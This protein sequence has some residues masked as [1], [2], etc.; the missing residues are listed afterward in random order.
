MTNVWSIAL[1]AS[2]P[3]QRRKN[4]TVEKLGLLKIGYIAFVVC[5]ATALA[6]P[7]QTFTSLVSF[8][9]IDGANPYAGL[10]Q[11]TDG[12]LY[13][14]TFQGP[15]NG[16]NQG[17]VFKMTTTGTLTPLYTFCSQANCA[18]GA[19][20]S[21]G[22]VLGTDGNFYGTTYYGGANDTCTDPNN[23]WEKGCGTVFK[24]TPGGTLTVLH[25]FNGTDG[26]YPGGGLVQGS[27]GN[28]YGATGAGGTG[29]NCTGFKPAGCGTIFK[30]TQVGQ[31][32]T[33]HTFNFTDGYQPHGPLVQG[34]DG[35]FYGATNE[36]VVAGTVCGFG[37]GTIFKITPGR[38]L[39]TLHIFE[40][41][42]GSFP[43]A[44]LVQATDGN[45][46]GTTETGGAYSSC[47]NWGYGCGTVFK[48][49]PSGTLT[50]LHSFDLT[51]GYR[52]E[53]TLVQGTDANLY[54]T[55]ALGGACSYSEGCGTLF[56]IT[57]TGVLTPLYKFCPQTGCADGSAP[58][59]GLV[60]DTNGTFYGATG[61]G[62]AFGPGTVFSLSVK[63]GPFV[64]TLPTSGK[65]GT[66]VTI[67]GTNLTGATKV[68]F[69]GTAATFSVTSKSEI[70]TTVPA[71]ATTGMVSV[72]TPNGTFKSNV[73]FR[74][75]PQ[76]KSFTPPS[77]PVGTEVQITGVSL[78]QTKVVTFGGVKAT[79]FIVNSDTQV[80]AAVPT[81]AKTGK[82]AIGTPG[83]TAVSATNFTVTE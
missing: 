6:S 33:L 73:V 59:A 68:S 2:L 38:T 60:Q 53:G 22:L 47:G 25:S 48:I 35:N 3:S 26:E 62:G 36:G 50:T 24:I 17:M 43:V 12:N 1:F 65:V 29:S 74:V 78:E 63:L 13:G 51:D 72:T 34:T 42:D 19:I 77:G 40:G 81:G 79:S 52:P 31:L 80:T 61:S 16:A 45:F 56:K 21:G 11:G 55:T 54:G 49:T 71:G 5:I 37:C 66:S 32:T 23:P 4:G 14:T 46:Y 15:T 58:E 28:F 64:K 82:I 20:P 9:G 75:T 39:T 83:G 10:V 7:A 18:D 30:I 69:N 57:L 67:L 27:D 8:N 44:G 41:P 70:K 76:I